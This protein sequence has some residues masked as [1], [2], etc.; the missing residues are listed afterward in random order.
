MKIL[1][2]SLL[3][4]AS[5]FAWAGESGFVYQGK[6]YVVFKDGK[7]TGKTF[8]ELFPGE[9]RK[10]SS[11]T[12]TVLGMVSYEEDQDSGVRCYRFPSNTGYQA[13]SCVKVR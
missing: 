8:E 9:N 6:T 2:V 1:A 13:L 7:K 3:T 10:P 4:V 5:C 12:S 11:M